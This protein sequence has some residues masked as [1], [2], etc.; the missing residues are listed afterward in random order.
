MVSSP[1]DP[2]SRRRFLAAVGAGGLAATSGCVNALGD[3]VDPLRSHVHH[4]D[5]DLSGDA[6]PWPTTGAD[7]HRSGAVDGAA[8]PRDAT[9]RR[10]TAAGQFVRAQPAVVG[11]R[12]YFGVDRRTG[13]NGDEFS[14]LV[15]IDIDADRTDG[16]V[17]W[18]EKGSGSRF[19]PT[20]AGNTVVAP[21]DE[22]V[23]ALDARVGTVFWRNTAARGAIAVVGGTCYSHADGLV[24]LD[25]V[26]GETRWTS[27]ATEAAAQGF[28]VG[29]DAIALACGD[30]GEGSLYCFERSDG[31]TRWR[32]REVG[33]SYASAVTD[34][35]RAYV[36]GTD[37]VVHAV[38]L[39]TGEQAWT[40]HFEGESY[41]RVAVSDGTVYA[42]GT[43]DNR[44]DAVDAASGDLEWQAAVGRF[45]LSPP[46]I[47]PGAVVAFGHTREGRQLFVLDRANGTE[48]HRHGLPNGADES[49]QPVVADGVAYVFGEPAMETQGYLYKVR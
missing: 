9:L 4:R 18:R 16:R 12:A 49:I 22:G 8:P 21:L 35:E 47:T 44:L 41:Q 13:E 25:A 30:G 28:A 29:E 20:V 24:A 2:A 17:A 32:Y 23:G 6:G 10:V 31:S 33:E 46:A 45:G 5:A 39:A 48:R 11:T 36:V 26:T 37:G 42:T 14:G 34:G 38:R 3:A 7:A 43:N 40:R 15:A 19:T 1:L 27:E